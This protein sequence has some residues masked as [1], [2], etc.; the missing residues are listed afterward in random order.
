VEPSFEATVDQDYDEVM[1]SEEAKNAFISEFV[2]VLKANLD[3][4]FGQDTVVQVVGEIR[5]GSIIVPLYI[6]LEGMSQ[7][8]VKDEIAGIQPSELFQNSRF[9]D[10]VELEAIT[11]APTDA[12]EGSDGGSNRDAVIG[13]AVGGAVG[14]S[15]VII[16]I[17]VA[18]YYI[19]FRK[20]AMQPYSTTAEDKPQPTWS[21]N[22][23]SQENVPYAEV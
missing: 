3:N 8:D 4:R 13:G 18:V 12:E 19:Y 23:A 9:Q 2:G 20:K 10:L 7:E 15:L 6:G 21:S 16:I 14:G 11:D 22:P 1:A 17:V 5:R